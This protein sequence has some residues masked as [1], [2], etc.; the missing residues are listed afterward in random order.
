MS[1][2][3]NCDEFAE[4][5][6]AY[7][8][9]EL[10]DSDRKK[11]EEHLSS[12]KLCQHKLTQV[13]SLAAQLSSLPLVEPSRDIVGNMEFNF[14][15]DFEPSSNFSVADSSAHGGE[16]LDA[17]HD[18]ELSK[19]ECIQLERHIAG[20][21]DCAQK[22]SQIEK[23]VQNIKQIPPLAP[24]RDLVSEF[25]FDCEPVIPLLDA[26]VDGE[27]N[28][29][30][31]IQVEQHTSRCAI[32]KA[33]LAKTANLISG[34][35]SLLVLKPSRNIV[36]SLDLPAE[37][38]ASTVSILPAKSAASSKTVPIRKSI[39]AGLGAVAAAA[40]VL[41]FAVNQQVIIPSSTVAN[42]PIAPRDQSPNIV[43]DNTVSHGQIEVPT[44]T[45]QVSSQAAEVTNTDTSWPIDSKTNLVAKAD[46]GV[47][48]SVKS[49]NNGSVK[50]TSA[51][52]TVAHNATQ[53]IPAS[54][55]S[56]QD[57]TLNELASLE[58]N[59]GVADA[60]GI[61]T[62]EDGLYDIKI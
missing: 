38:T 51:Q 2:S 6:D 28:S 24:Q 23:I 1:N 32:C 39:W 16:R 49:I 33:T 4:L 42:R 40:A 7:H 31:K 18:G 46:G 25:D 61:A 59:E 52:V 43:A 17:Y 29:D 44:D 58:T 55:V 47:A 8:D 20:C 53:E 13:S 54:V 48:P 10:S 36:D 60:L 19:E 5:L 45:Q 56:M 57:T 15:I 26:Y 11:V 9:A 37:I 14:D 22:L 62:D 21:A 12:C 30:E 34:L 35:K 27:L 3:N 50:S 41:V